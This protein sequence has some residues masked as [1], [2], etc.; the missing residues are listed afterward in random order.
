[1]EN[2]RTAL[3]VHL[4]KGLVGT[5]IAGVAWL[6]NGCDSRVGIEGTDWEAD[7]G[8]TAQTIT[9][10][11]LTVTTTIDEV[12]AVPGRPEAAPAVAHWEADLRNKALSIDDLATRC[13][14]M[15]PRNVSSMYAD[16]RPIREALTGPGVASGTT[17]TWQSATVTVTAQDRDIA[18]GYACPH[19]YPAGGE[20]GFDDADARHTV[21]RYLSR[22]VGKPLN[23][24]DR[25]DAYPLTCAAGR[26]W[27]PNG[28]GK[29]VMV[30]LAVNPSKAGTVKTF[31]DDSLKSEWPRGGYITVSVPVTTAAGNQTKQIY[32]L[33]SSSEGYCIGDVSG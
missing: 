9:M 25:E 26:T 2:G 3:R 22:A 14:T 20:V 31:V 11:P 30:P 15:A 21:R 6:A 33:K 23:T 13:W 10:P 32:T 4:R 16:T 27:D 12:G 28:T 17:V 1:M 18:T 24:A 8:T 5:L 19:V 7:S 29:P